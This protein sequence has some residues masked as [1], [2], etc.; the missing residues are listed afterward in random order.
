MIR[1]L[2]QN[3]AFA[4]LVSSPLKVILSYLFWSLYITE[5]LISGLGNSHLTLRLVLNSRL[6]PSCSAHLNSML[7]MN[8][9]LRPFRH[10]ESTITFPICGMLISLATES[11]PIFP[12]RM[13]I[14][15]SDLEVQTK[16][17]NT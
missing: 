17:S 10:T 15:G 14:P 5:T 9:E 2:L 1:I 12:S 4:C 11:S 6:R 13:C 7:A 16:E 3:S 8:S